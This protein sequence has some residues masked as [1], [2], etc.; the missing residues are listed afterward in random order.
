M[1]TYFTTEE[2]R[3]VLDQRSLSWRKPEKRARLPLSVRQE[4]TKKK[5]LVYEFRNPGWK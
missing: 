3:G 4:D 5:V 1:A 2:S